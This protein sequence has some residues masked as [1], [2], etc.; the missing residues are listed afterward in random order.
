MIISP[1]LKAVLIALLCGII[2]FAFFVV[3]TVFIAA[4]QVCVWIWEML[5]AGGGPFG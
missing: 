5:A 3:I 2:G 1:A 4:F